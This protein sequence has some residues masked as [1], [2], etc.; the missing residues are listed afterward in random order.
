[1]PSFAEVPEAADPHVDWR[2]HHVDRTMRHYGPVMQWVGLFLFNQGLTTFSGRYAN[3][4]LLFPMEQVFEDFVTDSFRRYQN[5]YAVGSQ[6]PQK[7]LA[8]FEGKDAFTM[9][10][11]ISLMEEGQTVVYI[12]DAKWKEINQCNTHNKHNIE[13]DD[14]YQLYAYGKRYEC[15]AVALVYPRNRNFTRELHYAFFDDEYPLVCL[16]F[17]IA[18]PEKSVGRSVKVLQKLGKAVNAAKDRVSK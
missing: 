11:D 13:Q 16:P 6:K 7:K 10:P 12:L 9:K 15:D 14:M 4:S 8:K 2:K 1:M 5:L 18:D 3:L 17:D